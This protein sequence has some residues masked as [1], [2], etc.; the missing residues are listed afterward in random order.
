MKLV[1]K[2]IIFFLASWLFGIYVFSRDFVIWEIHNTILLWFNK[3]IPSLIVMYLISSLLISS[4]AINLLVF[5][6]K[7]LKKIISFETDSGFSLFLVSI[8]VGNPSTCQYIKEYLEKGF[9]TEND[10]ENLLLSASFT[11]PLFIITMIKN[12]KVALI[13]YLSH[14][15]G[16]III[17]IFFTRKNNKVN[18][19][20]LI[21]VSFW[22]LINKLPHLLF[23]VLIYMI[24]SSLFSLLFISLN[25]PSIY[26]S[27]LEISNGFN[28]IL[29]SSENYYLLVML[30]S[31]N[32]LC[33][34]MQVLTVIDN[35]KYYK[36]FF[37][38][39]LLATILSLIIFIIGYHLF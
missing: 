10:A 38:G 14:F 5:I 28:S 16:N 11:N 9:I 31:F 29:S 23:I 1:L 26:L 33:I 17:A 22:H 7:P 39:R 25:I 2:V 35:R 36:R 12:T 3:T 27:F 13:L 37:V 18:E 30:T 34:H 6:F 4:N 32:G 24:I 15:L 8:L 19:K 21:N 20:R